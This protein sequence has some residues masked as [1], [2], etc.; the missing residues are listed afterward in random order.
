M[1]DEIPCKENIQ[2]YNDYTYKM[3]TLDK[4]E[5]NEEIYSII[6]SEYFPN[7]YMSERLKLQFKFKIP[8][9]SFNSSTGKS[10]LLDKLVLKTYR[11]ES[12]SS[13]FTDRLFFEFEKNDKKYK[14]YFYDLSSLDRFQYQIF[15]Y[16]KNCNIYYKYLSK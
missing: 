9:I 4:K 6:S 15:N 2:I 16:S 10:T 14:G 13:I 5:K 8:F 12:T 11:E 3:Y 1:I 7:Y